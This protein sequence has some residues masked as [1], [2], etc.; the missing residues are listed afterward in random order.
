MQRGDYAGS[1]TGGFLGKGLKIKE[2]RK[3]PIPSRSR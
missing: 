2:I 3:A 1:G